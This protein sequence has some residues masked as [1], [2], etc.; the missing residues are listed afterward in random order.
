MLLMEFARQNPLTQLIL[1]SPQGVEAIEKARRELSAGQAGE[2]P[3]DL[4]KVM[5]LLPA[6]PQ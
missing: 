5:E 6:R 4:I 2:F 3:R 1:L